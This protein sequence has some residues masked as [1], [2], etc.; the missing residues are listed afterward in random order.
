MSDLERTASA[1]EMLAAAAAAIGNE[2]AAPSDNIAMML[3]NG[4]GVL[5][6]SKRNLLSRSSSYQALITA[7]E[8]PVLEKLPKLNAVP[9]GERTQLLIKKLKLCSRVFDFTE[10]D[11][12]EE[13][14]V[15]RQ[16]FVEILEYINSSRGVLTEIVHGPLIHMV[17]QNLFR[18]LP[19]ALTD[20]AKPDDEDDPIL[21]ES[22]PHL[23][24]VYEILL[25][26]VVCKEIEPRVARVHLTESFIVNI[27]ELFDS[28][29]PREREYLKTVLHRIYSRITGLRPFIRR[30]IGSLFITVSSSD[31]IYNGL[32]ELLEILGSIINGFSVPLKEEHV[33]FLDRILMPLHKI[34]HLSVCHHHLVLC[35][36]Q[37][38]EHDRK[39]SQCVIQRLLRYWPK[40]DV[41]KT[42]LYVSEL[43]HILNIITEEDF[44]P[45]AP[46]ICRQL[47]A[48]IE[49]SSFQVAERCLLMWNNAHF[50]DLMRASLDKALPIF[51]A[52]L[53][54]NSKTHWHASV[55][56]LNSNVMRLFRGDDGSKRVFFESIGGIV[57]TRPAR[58]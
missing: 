17:Q 27:V 19:P 21:E 22:W 44:A 11:A 45:L 3:R 9:A 54:R 8:M 57:P 42:I 12:L 14:E 29:D 53:F 31:K 52:P 4:D 30:T 6:R 51:F 24:W 50:V 16:T 40:V 23:Q 2:P 1:K 34:R 25:R 5:R 18:A 58:S 7:D 37:F 39:L 41:Q 55:K 26:F 33:H 15:K 13:K 36:A 48:S 56:G 20:D 38:V 47:A 32:P 46:V 35:V 43:E 28:E 49:S 10:D